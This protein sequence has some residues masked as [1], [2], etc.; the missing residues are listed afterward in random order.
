MAPTKPAN[1][2][3]KKTAS[4][5]YEAMLE[6]LP[7]DMWYDLHEKVQSTMYWRYE[8]RE[9]TTFTFGDDQ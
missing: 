5:M 1:I 3:L 2:R 8:L 9:C 7:F 4:C 6:L